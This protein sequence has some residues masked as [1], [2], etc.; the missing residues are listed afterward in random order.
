MNTPTF[1]GAAD[2]CPD[3]DTTT[4]CDHLTH[5]I[6]PTNT[7]LDTAPTTSLATLPAFTYTGG[8]PERTTWTL[9]S[10]PVTAL[11]IQAGHSRTLHWHTHTRT[12]TTTIISAPRTAAHYQA[13]TPHPTSIIIP[14][15]PDRITRTHLTVLQQDATTARWHL[16]TLLEP[17][18]THHV[19]RASQHLAIESATFRNGGTTPTG[20]IPPLLDTE[21]VTTCVNRILYGTT[22]TNGGV[23]MRMI[24]RMT[25]P[26][27][28]T[29]MHPMAYLHRTIHRDA[30]DQVLRYT[31]DPHLGRA[32]R[33]W[34]TL[35]QPATLTELVD[36]YNQ[37]HPSAHLSTTRA[38]RALT[39]PHTLHDSFHTL[40]PDGEVEHTWTPNNN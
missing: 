28:L 21:A 38:I 13:N 31:G 33:R 37:A 7:W 12:G 19:K 2:T 40:T 1:N 3:P 29:T 10:Q 39:I 17:I 24:D 15:Q 23:T 6:I 34:V 16:L 18:V 25:R 30:L 8:Q 14:P 26:D 36:T 22:G 4:L 11:T 27:T 5:I 35:H 20:F 9:N 32:L